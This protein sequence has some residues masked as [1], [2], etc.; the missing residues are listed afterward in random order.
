MKVLANRVAAVI[1]HKWKQVAIQL[2]LSRGERKTIEK[3]ENEC[4]DQF[5]AVLEQWKA[6]AN[7]PF[8]WK[9]LVDVLQ[10]TSVGEQSLAEQLQKDF[11]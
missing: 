1:P 4:F 11:C 3:E 2:E 5:M 10:S 7:P 9:T 8:T 6:A